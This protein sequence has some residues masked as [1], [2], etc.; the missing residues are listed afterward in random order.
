MKPDEIEKLEESIETMTKIARDAGLDFYPMRYEVC[1]ADVLYTFG[2]YGMPTRFAHWSFGKAFHRMKLEY[3]LGLS[4]IY[5]LVINSNPCY[6]FLLDSNTLLQNQTVCAH[7]LAH[8]DFF[9]NN[10]MFARTPR[11]MV[12]RMAVNAERIRQY[13]LQYGRQRV[14]AL[15]DA[16]LALQ[17]HVDASAYGVRARTET[18]KKAKVREGQGADKNKKARTPY[19]DLW[20]VGEPKPAEDDSP[21]RRDKIPPAPQKDVMLFLIEH[22]PELEEWERDVLSVM[23]EEMLYFW[24]QLETK[25]MNEGWATYW[26]LRIMREMDL[27]DSDAIEFA[28][29]HSGVVLPSKTSINPYH[30]GL[31]IWEDI[32]KRWNEP[33]KEEQEKYGR[34]PGQGRAKMFEVREM[35]SDTS[36]LRNYLTKELVEKLDLYLYQKVG[37]EWRVVET[38]WEKVRDSICATRV[39]GGIPV[40]YVEDGDY[41]KS[42]ELFLRHAYEGLELDL[43]HLEKVLPYIQQLWGRTCHLQSVIEGRDVIFSCDGKRVQRRFV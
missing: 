21:G 22:S 14:E 31:A 34:E 43:K 3:D 40:L 19:D 2:A 36:F 10:A 7:V 37:S 16:G 6:A 28:K 39:N 27:D 13:E 32:E 12:D 1:P 8:C 42:G 25:I 9:K 20:S 33:T 38:D 17:E 4:R 35:E 24:P 26:H 29:M 15:I 11:D 18:G 5:E 23:R 30:I 41:N